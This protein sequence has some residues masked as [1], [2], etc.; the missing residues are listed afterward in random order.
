MADLLFVHFGVTEGFSPFLRSS[1]VRQLLHSVLCKLHAIISVMQFRSGLFLQ[2]FILKWIKIWRGV[3]NSVSLQHTKKHVKSFIIPIQCLPLIYP[4]GGG[5]GGHSRSQHMEG[6]VS[7][8]IYVY[9]SFS[10]IWLAFGQIQSGNENLLC[11]LYKI[12]QKSLRLRYWYKPYWFNKFILLW[13]PA[14]Y[15]YDSHICYSYIFS[16]FSAAVGDNA[17]TRWV[18]VHLHTSPTVTTRAMCEL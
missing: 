5:E 12:S 7:C 16:M 1:G 9:T 6:Q 11:D 14:K 17:F 18:H 3:P 15:I 10:I 8:N 4:G 13:Y 2:Q